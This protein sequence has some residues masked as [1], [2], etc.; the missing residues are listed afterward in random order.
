MSMSGLGEEV[1]DK[2]EFRVL[3][4]ACLPHNYSLPFENVH[5]LNLVRCVT[6]I[7]QINTALREKVL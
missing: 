4:S 7:H 1:L 2:Y 3:I 6:R 5:I